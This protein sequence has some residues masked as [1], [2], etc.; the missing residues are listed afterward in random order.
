M[1]SHDELMYEA[2]RALAAG[3]PIA[4]VVGRAE[5]RIS[6][7]FQKV[8]RPLLQKQIAEKAAIVLTEIPVELS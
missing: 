3:E 1:M 2:L 7:P 6:E 4:L 8:L 5:V